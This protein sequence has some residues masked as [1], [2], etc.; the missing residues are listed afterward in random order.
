MPLKK[1]YSFQLFSLYFFL[2]HAVVCVNY[3]GCFYDCKNG[4][5]DLNVFINDDWSQTVNLCISNC[6][7]YKYAGVQ[8]R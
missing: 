4:L 6:N 1:L 5:R 7:G 3:L 2:F 8:H